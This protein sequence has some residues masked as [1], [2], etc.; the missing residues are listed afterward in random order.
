MKTCY[1]CET[2][3]T[4]QN[5]SVEH[6]IINACGGKL[7]SSNLLCSSCN[8]IFGEQFDKELAKTTNDLAN[9][10]LVKRERGEPQKI[11]GISE[12]G[13]EEYYLEFGGDISITKPTI[14]L[15][16]ID[17]EEIEKRRINVKAPNPKILAQTLKGLKRKYPTLNIDNALE[18]ATTNDKPF[19]EAIEIKSS[20]GGQEVFKSVLKTAINFYMLNDGQRNEIKH[21]F[22]YLEN[23]SDMDVVWM[24]Y[25]DNPIYKSIENEITHVLK[26]VGDQKE[27]ILYAYVELF[28]VHCFIVKL[29][30]DYSGKAI[31]ADYVFNVHTHQVTKNVT[32]L[33]LDRE[34]LL[35]LFINK[36][37]KPFVNVQK[38]Y[39]RVLGISQILQHKNHINKI[40]SKAVDTALEG[41]EEDEVL[42][43][44]TIIKMREE[45]FKAMAPLIYGNIKK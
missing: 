17:N 25:P 32:N 42:D 26:L 34:K 14:D 27:K 12:D 7:K 13:Q 29:N 20:I 39:Q 38:R 30:A 2:E 36:D 37:A 15:I 6:I 31:D 11:K 23:S 21:L 22:P 45:V 5:S 4:K 35:D 1:R 18:K 28:Y 33:Q 40:I 24:H 41:A 19:N 3:L 10:L 16:D 44:K 8:S 9:L 43:Q